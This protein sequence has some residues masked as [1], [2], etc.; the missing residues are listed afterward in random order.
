MDLRSEW[1]RYDSSGTP[2]PAY[3]AWPSRAP[4][5][6]PAILIIHEVWGLNDHIRDLVHR[7]V[8]AGYLAAAPDHYAHGGE[9]PPELSTER[10]AAVEAFVRTVPL[11]TLMTPS[12][13]EGALAPLPE[14]Q[15]S[16]IAGTL[17]VLFSPHRPVERFVADLRAAVSFLAEHP[18]ARRQ[19]VGAVGYCMGGGLC[20]LLACTDPRLA[21]AA[22][23]YGQSPPAERASQISCPVI[24][25]YGGADSRITDGV[26]GFA[27]AMGAA[28]KSFEYVVYRGAPHA[29]F[30]DEHA[31]YR[32]DAARDAWVRTLSFFARHVA[33][34]APSASPATR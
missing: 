4:G 15:R 18:M 10:I 19:R 8:A 30:N 5:P 26:P 17:D 28:G 20:A 33:P 3:I 16:Q 32:V 12:Q 21:A 27:E 24:G 7:F 1:V 11:A 2:V 31:T 6:L 23:Y 9:R 34:E 25:F 29:F 14:P 22:I 13:R